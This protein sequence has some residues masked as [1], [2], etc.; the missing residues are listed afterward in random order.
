MLEA[1]TKRG[2]VASVIADLEK[3]H[4]IDFSNAETN[5]FRSRDR[6]K[7]NLNIG[8]LNKEKQLSLFF[9]VA[10]C[11]S[12]NSLEFLSSKSFRTISSRLAERWHL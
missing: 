2:N 7:E 4:K 9:S 12:S 8:K 1:T 3:R 5:R 11:F 6:K 10:K